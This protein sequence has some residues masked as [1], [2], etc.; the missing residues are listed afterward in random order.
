VAQ[1]ILPDGDFRSLL[2]QTHVPD[3][4]PFCDIIART[5]KREVAKMLRLLRALRRGDG[6]GD[7]PDVLNR[8][9]ESIGADRDQMASDLLRDELGSDSTQRADAAIRKVPIKATTIQSSKGLAEDYVFIT[10][11]DDLYFIKD[12][13]KANITDHDVC[14]FLV[15]LT[16]A[17]K[18]VYLISSNPRAT[19]TFLTWISPDRIQDLTAPGDRPEPDALQ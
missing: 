2:E 3:P 6:N 12:K 19:S 1:S 15:A 14:S 7:D 16:R 11:F 18:R 8:L 5:H 9:L 10:H 4:K 13:D 17:R